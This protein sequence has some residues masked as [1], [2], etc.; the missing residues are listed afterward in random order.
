[1][2]ANSS[3]EQQPSHGKKAFHAAAKAGN[4]QLLD[5]AL[6]PLVAAV[7]AEIATPGAYPGVAAAALSTAVGRRDR[8]GRTPF[9]TACLHG[10]WECAELL[11]EAGSNILAIDGDSNGCLHLA[12][13]NGHGHVVEQVGRGCRAI[14][15][16]LDPVLKSR[17]PSEGS[18]EL[19]TG[20]CA[21][22]VLGPLHIVLACW[23]ATALRA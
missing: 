23:P 16:K 18:R 21:R 4:A 9:L 17:V 19:C 6:A 5:Q 15:D 3:K 20:C 10:S 2:G 22:V 8:A 11:L 7:T 13:I 12:C 1:M 14:V